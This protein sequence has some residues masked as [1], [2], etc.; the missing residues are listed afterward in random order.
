MKKIVL[1][2]VTMLS[3]AACGGTSAPSTGTPGTGNPV[4]PGPVT[5]PLPAWLVPTAGAPVGSGGG[6][7]TVYISPNEFEIGLMTLI[8]EVRVSGTV[9]GQPV[10]AGSCAAGVKGL[11]P[12]RYSGLLAHAARMHTEYMRATLDGGHV[13][14][15]PSAPQFWGERFSDRV[16]KS[17]DVLKIKYEQPNGEI[18][19][20]SERSA[21]LAVVAYLNSPGHCKLIIRP[22][23]VRFG[24]G[25]AGDL[26][27]PDPVNDGSDPQVISSR[28]LAISSN[29]VVFDY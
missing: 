29:A 10:P 8:N 2:V 6:V 5:T 22:D 18:V 7:S 19:G 12:L 9:N 27:L 13:E 28:W 14:R 25:W 3:L 21:E 11:Q 26:S 23:Y 4:T 1:S 24:A 17:A 20:S 16:Q 15:I